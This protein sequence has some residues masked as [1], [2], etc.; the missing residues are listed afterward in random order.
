MRAVKL[1]IASV[2]KSLPNPDLASSGAFVM[3]RLEAMATLA[4]VEIV[5]PVPYFPLVRRLPGWARDE[6]RI[7]GGVAIHHAPMLYVPG[8]LKRLDGRWLERAVRSPLAALHTRRPLDIVDAHFGY[9]D[10]VG[11]V[12]AAA[13]LGVPS[14]VTIRGLETDY[15][16]DPSI[17]PQILRALRCAAGCIS[18]SHSLKRLV[19]E[20]GISEGHV[21]VIPNAVDRAVF[22]PGERLE[23]RIE[24][25]LASDGPL[26]VSVG[27]IIALKRH[28]V[29]IEAIARIARQTPGVKLAIIGSERDEPAYL[30]SLRRRVEELGLVSSVHFV[31]AVAPRQVE[32]WLTAADVF[33]LVSAREGCCNAVLEALACGRP[34]VTTSVGDNA[35]FVA[36]GVNGSLVPVDD[37]EATAQAL[38]DS[39]TQ[40]AWDAERI[41]RG[42]SVGN[43][44]DV[45]TQVIDYFRDRLSVARRGDHQPTRAVV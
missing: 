15:L 23:A 32:R 26:I 25:G 10:G 8:V 20:H 44:S 2:C 14:F 35:H 30:P 41:S 38:L 13:A 37:S 43:W 9:P 1:R 27:T 7:M 11:A 42:L 29:V 33:C 12:R 17:A 24:L 4:D 6:S 36:N 22:R 3:R 16:R 28:H 40:R 31:G 39:V 5:Q 18:V 34:V 45:A 19:I 21:K